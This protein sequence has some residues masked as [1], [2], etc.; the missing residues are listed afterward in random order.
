MNIETNGL[1]QLKQ[2]DLKKNSAKNNSDSSFKD[3]FMMLEKEQAAIQVDEYLNIEE[4]LL[5]ENSQNSGAQSADSLQQM[6]GFSSSELNKVPNS[7]VIN[8]ENYNSNVEL[9]EQVLNNDVNINK[10]KEQTELKA[11]INFAQ[12]GGDAFSSFLNNNS[13]SES[14]DDLEVDLSVLSTAAENLAMINK[15]MAE[16][17]ASRIQEVGVVIDRTIEATSL[18]LS[19]DDIAFFLHLVN[20]NVNISEFTSQEEVSSIKISEI[21]TNMMAECM[22]NNK[23]FRLNFDNGISVIIKVSSEGKISANFLPGTDAAET[24]LKNNM[25]NLVQRFE[26]EGI[27]YEELTHQKQKRNNQQEKKDKD[28]E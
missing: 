4:D 7:A 17:N 23:A 5:I 8:N 18:N 26:E 3:E 11:D 16:F 15:S 1:N 12:N 21:L 20:H 10:L 25:A 24:Y 19:R 14:K 13:Y 9:S 22:R 2:G 27:P 6:E 28:N